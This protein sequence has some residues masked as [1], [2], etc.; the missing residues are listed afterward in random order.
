MARIKPTPSSR[1]DVALVLQPWSTAITQTAKSRIAP[2]ARAFIH[3][4]SGIPVLAPTDQTIH[5]SR[6]SSAL[7]FLWLGPRDRDRV[8][9]SPARVPKL[10]TE[11]FPSGFVR[12]FSLPGGAGSIC[13]LPQ[14]RLSRRKGKHGYPPEHTA[15]Q[16]FRQV[17]PG[18]EPCG[19]IRRKSWLP[20][21]LRPKPVLTDRLSTA[22]EV[23][24]SF[25]RL[26]E[27]FGI[28]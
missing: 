11:A 1:F 5:P 27:K 19:S 22:S 23:L 4:L 2:V 15:K 26:F 25:S 8:L 7:F 12:H 14:P 17:A 16:P 3:M 28:W 13:R 18:Q 6:N 9:S 20:T 10:L 24:F 21:I